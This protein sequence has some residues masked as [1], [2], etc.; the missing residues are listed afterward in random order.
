M[1]TLRAALI[2]TL[3]AL[4]A[5]A[6]WWAR[7]IQAQRDA[8]QAAATQAQALRTLAEAATA[9]SEQDRQAEQAAAGRIHEVI[10][11]AH[12]EA[13][14]ARRDAAAA[15]RTAE[16]LRQHL[17]RLTAPASQAA[18]DPAAA[19]GGPP[20]GGTGL[21]LAKLLGRADDRAGQLAAFADQ[22]HIAGSACERAYDEVRA[23]LAA[24]QPATPTSPALPAGR[25]PA[26]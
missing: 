20:A 15:D 11:H 16:R 18:S 22:A 13:Q 17:A 6:G 24:T 19:P 23:A 2:I 26:P 14:A 25:P 12:A 9:A 5:G 8:A 1:R 7:G 10:T 21:V 4:L 3:A